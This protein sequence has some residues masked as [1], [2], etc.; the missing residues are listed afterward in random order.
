MLFSY[1]VVVGDLGDAEDLALQRVHASK[2]DYMES[3]A[4]HFLWHNVR[5][6]MHNRRKWPNFSR[7]LVRDGDLGDAEDLALHDGPGRCL[8]PCRAHSCDCLR[9][10]SLRV[11]RTTNLH[12]ARRERRERCLRQHLRGRRL[13]LRCARA[14]FGG[15]KWSHPRECCAEIW[16]LWRGPYCGIS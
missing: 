12:R 6:R 16:S 11:A 9:V 5:I 13:L 4:C 10:A 2:T 7:D 14:C 15:R 3:G 8:L 1:Q